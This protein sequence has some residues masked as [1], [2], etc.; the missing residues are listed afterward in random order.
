ML[1]DLDIFI[2]VYSKE[3]ILQAQ[4][5]KALESFG[6][7][8]GTSLEDCFDKGSIRGVVRRLNRGQK[9]R[10]S[11]VKDDVEIE[12]ITSIT[13][14]S[15]ILQGFENQSLQETKTL[16]TSYSI[17]LEETNNRIS[18]LL[19]DALWLKTAVE[20]AIRPMFMVD[21]ECKVRFINDSAK[22]V[23]WEHFS[24]F[25]HFMEVPLEDQWLGLSMQNLPVFYNISEREDIFESLFNLEEQMFSCNVRRV[26]KEAEILGYCIEIENVTEERYRL[27]QLARMEN[28]VEG[29]GTPA[30]LCDEQGAIRYVNPALHI[31]FSRYQKSLMAHFALTA[32]EKKVIYGWELKKFFINQMNQPVLNCV[33]PY[34]YRSEVSFGEA[35]FSVDVYALQD[36]EIKFAGYVVEWRDLNPQKEYRLE[37]SRILTDL[38]QGK[39]HTRASTHGMSFF[40]AKLLDELN[41]MLDVLSHPLQNVLSMTN[42]L[43]KGDLQGDLGGEEVWQGELWTLQQQWKISM[44]DL[45][46]MLQNVRDTSNFIHDN[47]GDVQNVFQN[48]NQQAENQ[49][50]LTTTSSASL[51][52]IS[53]Q[54]TES[55][56]KVQQLSHVLL[57]NGS[58][59][60]NM[61]LGMDQ[62]VNY[63]AVIEDSH[64]DI[65]NTLEFINEIAFQTNLLSLNAAIEAARAGRLGK[66]FGV[67]ADEVQNLA[68]RSKQAAT[69]SAVVIQNAKDRILQGQ[70][71]VSQLQSELKLLLNDIL[72]QQ[73]IALSINEQ[74]QSQVVQINDVTHSVSEINTS[75]QYISSSL[76]ELTDKV[77]QIYTEIS[78]LEASILNFALVENL[79]DDEMRNLDI[80]SFY[81]ENGDLIQSQ[82]EQ[83]ISVLEQFISE[84][85]ERNKR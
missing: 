14:T 18:S 5:T 23:F 24:K 9:P 30:M 60:Q 13:T 21:T 27:R 29:L 26:S 40:F 42:R 17:S 84:E 68:L 3:F 51:N 12:F 34:H 43:S 15:I 73:S 53:I 57:S 80:A 58:L 8:E 69:D 38:Q 16:L 70:Q 75:T 20:Q 71:H 82:A 48:I 79:S 85:D 83:I 50:Q 59:V 72:E 78:S 25:Q 36:D 76:S 74:A 47:L 6:F 41:Q 44:R 81:F 7:K 4:N 31:L 54:N 49:S 35:L 63:M 77:Q 33:H 10:F 46:K 52:T 65:T 61:V 55:A 1:N 66:G 19:D 11:I 32:Y 45:S 28:M 39:I 62:L 67:V 2:L 37:V 56:S 64:R 22:H